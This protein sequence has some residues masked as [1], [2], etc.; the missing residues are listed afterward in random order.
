MSKH[1][2]RILLKKE[3]GDEL[4]DILIEAL[5]D[6]KYLTKEQKKRKD[7]M[8]EFR[9]TNYCKDTV[10]SQKGALRDIILKKYDINKSQ[11]KNLEYLK[12]HMHDLIHKG[13]IADEAERLMAEGKDL[14]SMSNDEFTERY[15]SWTLADIRALKMMVF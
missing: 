1:Q 7:Y 4:G 14:D 2:K 13:I 5:A 12:E 8:E 15:K 6:L 11:K 3:F 10:T 9:K